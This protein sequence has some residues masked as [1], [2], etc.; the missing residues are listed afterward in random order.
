MKSFTSVAKLFFMVMMLGFPS[1]STLA[2]EAKID[3]QAP[4]ISKLTT[5]EGIL[6]K[7]CNFLK[8]NSQFSVQM[9]ITYDNVLTT[10][11]KVQFAAIQ[12]T[13]VSK[14]DRIFSEYRGDERYTEFRY[15]GKEF[16]LYSPTQNFYDTK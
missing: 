13:K 7:A 5:A 1:L 9:D 14:P 11:E 2:Q 3:E 12:K 10:G 16:T 8:E 15:D 6:Q 4:D